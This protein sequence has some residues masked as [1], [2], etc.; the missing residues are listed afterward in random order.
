MSVKCSEVVN[1][2]IS[3]GYYSLISEM[4]DEEIKYIKSFKTLINEYFKKT[5]NLQMASGSKL[6]KLPDD[7][8]NATWLDSAPFLKLTQQIPKI[9][10]KQIE[11]LDNFMT[12]IEK[13]ITS[14]DE[15]FKSKSSEIKKYNQKYD[16]A[17]N[18]LIK[19]YID[20][21]KI[22]ISFLNSITKS[23]DIIMKSLE[24]KKKIED[25]QNGKIKLNEAE[26]KL[27]IDKNKEYESQ[28][29]S[30][31][32][33]AKKY[34]NEY[35]NIIKSSIKVEDKFISVIND[36]ITG[37]K[38]VTGEI[39]DKLKDTI[40][41][42]LSSIRDSFKIPLELIDNNL[43]YMK[44]LDEK[45]IINKAMESTFNNE[46]KLI[47]ITPVR[48]CLKAF[49]KPYNE[50][51]KNRSSRGSNGK[52]KNKNKNK[53]DNDNQK[54]FVKFED[55]F[56]E[57]SYF[58][59]DLTLLTVK[60]MFNNFELVNHNGLNLQV[61]EEKNESRKYTIKLISNMSQEPNK[62]LNE[63]DFINIDENSPFTENDKNNLKKLLIKHH[64]R[65]IFLHKLN[66]YRT[67]SLFE[68]K[69][70]EFFTLVEF[71]SFLIDI[72]RKEKDY[73][74]VEM[75]IILSKTYYKLEKDQKI[76]IQNL[77]KS[78]EFFKTKDLWEELLIYSVS[79]EVIRSKKRDENNID[80]E[81]ILSEKNSNIVFSQLLS[82]IDNMF[83]FDVEGNLI[84]QIIEPRIEY[85][86]VNEKLK[87]TIMDVIESKI[88]A[89]KKNEK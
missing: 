70:K 14:L 12:E 23:E 77:I 44:K 45:D 69:E 31:I 82:L 15:F 80:N 83:D 18:D 9:I 61:E 58:E 85:Y 28:K 51:T 73:H 32:N 65:V 35:K 10:Q 38:N 59:D 39:T 29:K 76:Y 26:L 57:M 42:F 34:E 27:L 64:N 4:F 2:K 33:S 87:K 86:K 36:S 60:E 66:D 71:F 19:K 30:Q 54:A 21:E 79:K 72:S 62:I 50:I 81:D 37:I 11:F 63:F 5:L 47:H 3:M 88:N 43:S 67:C 16:D 13:S 6:G 52:S 24:N 41:V 25:A 49:E 20:V 74:C 89:K 68:L 55:G 48:Y 40:I 56:E 8:A 1:F 78:N 22:K 75:T 84:K 7:F 46:S 53:G 17:S